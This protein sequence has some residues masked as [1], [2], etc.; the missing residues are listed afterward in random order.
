[1]EMV[2]GVMKGQIR[3]GYFLDTILDPSVVDRIVQLP[4]GLNYH[5]SQSVKIISD[6][7]V[8]VKH[9]NQQTRYTRST[10]NIVTNCGACQQEK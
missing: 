2:L 1:M 8:F 9:L 3:G 6:L 10:R 4:Y 5:N 7:G